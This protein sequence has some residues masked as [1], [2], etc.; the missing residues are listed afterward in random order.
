MATLAPSFLFGSSLFLEV[1]RTFITSRMSSNFD[2]IR[3]LTAELSALE[4]LKNILC[5]GHSCI[6]VFQWIFF[7]LAGN[8]DN[9][10]ISHE[11]EFRPDPFSD[12]RVSCPLVFE[13]SI[14]CIVAT[15][16]PSILIGSSS[17]LEATRI[18]ITS[19]MSLNLSQIRPRTAE[20]AALEC[21][22]NQF[23]VSSYCTCLLSGERPLPLGYLFKSE[24]SYIFTNEPR[25]EKTRFLPTKV[26]TSFVVTAN[27]ISA[28]VFVTRIVQF[29]FFLNLKSQACSLFL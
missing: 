16:A 28:F 27:L 20:L 21:L 14:F 6:F 25:H 15:L 10:N 3:P 13:N 24:F 4:C 8:K 2:Q 11:F 12:C 26:Q 29:L 7:I 23:L 22:K 9:Y 1:T 18:I 5:C 19:W 17:F